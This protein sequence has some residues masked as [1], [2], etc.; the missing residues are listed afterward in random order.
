[1]TI[2]SV[3]IANRGEIAV[4]INRAAKA[5]G[6]R[7]VQVHSAADADLLAVRL[8]D[9]A[10]DIGPP[11]AKKS[12]LNIEA[13][14]AAAKAA[15]VD[16]IHPGYGF[17][18][19]NA[20][21]AE[22]VVAAGMIFVGPDAAAI[23]LLGDKV[24]A[25][26]VAAKAGVPTVPGSDG[27]VSDPGERD[28]DRRAHRLS[29]DDQGGGRRR[30]PGHPH[31]RHHGRVRAPFSAGLSR[32][33]RRVWR[34]R[35]LYREGDRARPAISRSRSS[36]TAEL[37]PLLRAR[38]LAA[39][40]AAEVLGGSACVR[41]CQTT[42]AQRLCASAVALVARGRLQRCGHGRISLR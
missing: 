38:M 41:R 36:A 40:A 18:S 30:R 24:A 37:R 34:W 28:S 9:E 6:L 32:S 26:Q 12:Y 31:R 1:M 4:R 20:D 39:T 15:N 7:T 23:R 21:F 17:L 14:L 10:I 25:R 16:A 11:A 19:E 5:L 33:R 22:A 2:R 13:V 42:C 3:L 27:R 29:G 35:A 8:A